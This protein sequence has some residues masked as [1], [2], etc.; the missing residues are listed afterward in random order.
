MDAQE[1]RRNRRLAGIRNLTGKQ[2]TPWPAR[3]KAA[4]RPAG[5]LRR[6]RPLFLALAIFLL[7]STIAKRGRLEENAYLLAD[8]TGDTAIVLSGFDG[9]ASMSVGE[10]A[11][12]ILRM[13]RAVNE[14]ARLYNAEDPTAYW[15]LRISKQ[16]EA[17]YIYEMAKDTVEDYAARDLIYEKEAEAAGFIPDDGELQA[18]RYE[19]EREWLKMTER[20]VSATGLTT[21]LIE[22]AMKR[23]KTAA[24]Y[25][26]SLQEQGIGG[27]DVGGSYYA[28]LKAKYQPL[29]SKEV[30]EQLRLGKITVN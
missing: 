25:M 28:V 27:V 29:L 6:Y 14:Q 15:K 21:E 19:A 8:H 16:D 12:Y 20:E 17:S 10:L 1:A 24:A 2:K 3:R 22:S 23:E 9:Q 13:E 7:G 18:V 4:A 30:G 26:N 5:I 11:W